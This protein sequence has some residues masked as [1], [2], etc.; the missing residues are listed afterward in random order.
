MLR[1]AVVGLFGLLL[2]LGAPTAL[3]RAADDEAPVFS[4]AFKPVQDEAFHQNLELLPDYMGG[5]GWP[6]AIQILQEMLDGDEDVFVPVSR[7]GADGKKVTAWVGARAEALRL[8]ASLPA[9]GRL[10]HDKVAKP[11]AKALLESARTK[12]DWRVVKEVARRYPLTPAGAEAVKL[13][14]IHHLDRGDAPQAVRWFQ[15]WRQRNAK[16]ETDGIGMYLMWAALH[17][18]GQPAEAEAVWQKLKLHYPNGLKLDER[19]VTL[20]DLQKP[21]STAKVQAA[22]LALPWSTFAGNPARNAVAAPCAPAALDLQWS[23]A[24][25]KSLPIVTLLEEA[26]RLQEERPQPVLSGNFPIVVGN[27]IVYRTQGGI[28]ALDPATGKMVWDRPLEVSLERLLSEPGSRAVVEYWLN[29]YLSYHPQIALEN[30]AIGCLSADQ[31]YVYAV[32]DLPV[33]PF[34]SR[35]YTKKGKKSAYAQQAPYDA[36]VAVAVQRSRLCALDAA[37]GK[38]AWEVGRQPD[39][40]GFLENCLYLGPPLAVEGKLYGMAE[41]KGYLC[42]YGLEAATGKLLW[43]QCLGAPQYALD[44]DGGRRLQA[45]HLSYDR[46]ILLC[47][48]NGGAVVAY[49]VHQGN[50]LWAHAYRSKAVVSGPKLKG[51]RSALEIEIESIPNLRNQLQVS[52]PVICQGKVVLAS[53]D[54]PAVQCIRIS[55]GEVLWKVERT[56]DDLFFAGVHHDKVLLVGR[57]TCRA[58]SLADGKELWQTEVGVP[59]GQGVFVGDSYVLPVKGDVPAKAARVV[60]V[61]LK[62]G[63][64]K[65]WADLPGQATAG[66]LLLVDGRVIAQNATTIASWAAGK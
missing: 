17:R 14:G 50:L 6:T 4:Q 41:Y 34:V 32:D 63:Q 33:L 37:T 13:L 56:A 31:N 1:A 38:V 58:L 28:Q 46:G 59:T 35:I 62:T 65:K 19:K 24:T 8:L 22:A 52:A 10:A 30:T 18:N 29:T 7:T 64:A 66:N 15:L 5:D 43:K 47:P 26:V 44:Y 42:V 54:S 53:P 12:G 55:D 39:G 49:D 51:L 20:A 48:T 57:Q 16:W 61:D 2:A 9:E 27:K 3:V 11:R 45:L 25:T 40:L 36:G 21:W 23:T 60:S